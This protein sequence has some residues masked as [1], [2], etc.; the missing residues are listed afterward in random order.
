MILGS[1]EEVFEAFNQLKVLIIGDSMIDT[2]VYGDVRRISPEAP[3][4]VVDVTSKDVRPGGAA[5]V[6]LN[7][8]KLG[9]TAFICSVVGDDY[10]GK[11]LRDLLESFDVSSDYLITDDKRITTVKQRVISDAHHLLRIDKEE[12][13]P[14]SSEVEDRLFVHILRLLP[15]MDAIVL[16]DYDKGVLTPAFIQKIVERARQYSVPVAADPKVRNFNFY[17]GV[18]LFKPNF[19]EFKSG[20]GQIDVPINLDSLRYW[21][22]QLRKKI[23]YD[24]LLLTLS[25][26]GVFYSCEGAEG[27]QLAH[28]RSISDVSGAGDTVISIAAVCLALQLPLKFTAEL[29]NLG[30]G[31]VCEYSGVVSINKDRLLGEAQ[32]LEIF[33]QV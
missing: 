22:E 31:I 1:I 15:D 3:V 4:P 32:K 23:S 7:V 18:S 27:Y 16:E 30:G 25:G 17:N 8:Q 20:I 5:N 24:S 9:A 21:N 14:I 11:E 10:E 12:V 19:T 28:F 6:A 13:T 26:K 29:A 2:Y 33:P